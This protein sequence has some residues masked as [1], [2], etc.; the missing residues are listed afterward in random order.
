MN[1]KRLLLLSL[2]MVV[3]VVPCACAQ[4]VV[5]ISTNSVWRYLD[6]GSDQGSAWQ[7]LGFDDS[8]WAVGAAPLG[9]GLSNITTTQAVARV[10]YYHR[11]TFTVTQPEVYSNL[12]LRVRRDDGA[13]AYLN[14]QEIFRSNMPTGSIDFRTEATLSATGLTQFNFYTTN[15]SRELLVAGTNQLAVEIHQGSSSSVDAAFALELVGELDASPPNIAVQPRNRSAV[16]GEA[17]NLSFVV[18]GAVP[19]TIEWR[20]DGIPYLGSTSN[21]LTFDPVQ[22]SDA[23]EYVAIA[24]NAFGSVTSQVARLAVCVPMANPSFETDLFAIAPGKVSDNGPITGWTALSGNGLSSTAQL[25]SYAD[26]GAIPDGTQ[27]AFLSEPGALSQVIN[28]LTL[29]A[30]YRVEYDE[31]ARACCEGAEPSLEVQVGGVPIVAAH[32]VSS[33]GGNNP[34]HHVVSGN[35]IATQS[36]LELSFIK[37]NAPETD[38]TVLIDN[39]C[40]VRVSLN[41]SPLVSIVSPTNS[42]VFIPGANVA[43]N[44]AASDPDGSVTNVAL[45]M[46]G[47]LQGSKGSE[48]YDFILGN[49]GLGTHT[50]TSVAQDA[51]GLSV[52]SA[53]V[54]ISI[55]LEPGYLTLIPNR[56]CWR[57]FD[58]GIDLGEDW[59]SLEFPDHTWSRGLAELGYGDNDEATVIGFGPDPEDRHITTY[60]RHAFGIP[61]SAAVTGLELRLKRDDGAVVYL[62]GVEV[63]RD[64]LPAG[65]VLFNSPASTSIDG[66]QE[67]TWLVVKIDPGFLVEGENLLAVELHQDSPTNSDASFD[68]MLLAKVASARPLLTVSVS[69]QNL[70]RL[71]WSDTT[72]APFKLQTAPALDL[73]GNTIWTEVPSSPIAGDGQLQVNLPF[74]SAAQFFRLFAPTESLQICQPPIIAPH[75]QATNVP[76]GGVIQLAVNVLGTGP[77]TYQWHKNQRLIVGETNSSVTISNATRVDGGAYAVS[78]QG[79]CGCAICCPMTVVVN[80]APIQMTDDFEHRPQVVGS[81]LQLNAD[82]GGASLEPGEP[83]HPTKVYG[84]TVWAKWVAP[85]T[86][87]VELDTHGSGAATAAAVYTGGSL[88]GLTLVAAAGANET[89]DTSRLLFDAVEGIEYQ[90]AVDG[91]EGSHSICLNLQMEPGDSCAPRILT[92]PKSQFAPAGQDVVLKV[93]AVSC[94]FLTYQWYRD[95]VAVSGADASTLIIGGVQPSDAASFRV[96]VTAGGYTVLSD[97]VSVVVHAFITPGSGFFTSP[98]ADYKVPTD[99]PCSNCWNAYRAYIFRAESSTVNNTSLV[100]NQ[101]PT[102]LPVDLSGVTYTPTGVAKLTVSTQDSANVSFDTLIQ[103]AVRAFV[104]RCVGFTTCGENDSGGDYPKLS[105]YKDIDVSAT[106]PS[107]QTA[108]GGL[109]KYV[110]VKVYYKPLSAGPQ[111]VKIMYNYS[112]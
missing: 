19:L 104:K 111:N 26:N 65:S 24:S 4:P 82:L 78:V 105:L 20:K 28:G 30:T 108:C 36:S 76:V 45:Y 80:G 93:E 54:E 8:G 34:Y 77:F 7:G 6:D 11:R 31:N 62:N 5:L 49:I 94:S 53:P 79:A 16:V 107:G 29:G 69:G 73:G 96:A 15:V 51:W 12:V 84:Q 70:A 52:T 38:S 87:V 74:G 92:Q 3:S 95:G 46:D 75:L 55:P 18:T 61:S 67:Y 27:V 58:R 17:V 32:R 81:S 40:V 68:L 112:Q 66:L 1:S 2:L 63:L 60:F 57:Y 42:E 106:A 88:S 100:I 50:L 59:R 72:V 85:A 23:G 47:T 44:V 22:F 48:P 102:I 89:W 97:P 21:E 14:Q 37:S 25:G 43:V 41:L 83:A 71:S 99:G 101:E 13:V 35:F 103:A 64:N 10:T 91:E 109:S 110:Y 56:S 86:G 9:Y 33:V 39:V 98:L 90:L